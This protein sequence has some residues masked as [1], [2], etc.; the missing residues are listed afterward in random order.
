MCDIDSNQTHTSFSTKI[1]TNVRGHKISTEFVNGHS[2]LNHLKWKIFY[3]FTEKYVLK[4][5]YFLKTIT[6]S[7]K[8]THFLY[9]NCCT[10]TIT[11]KWQPFEEL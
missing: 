11:R 5:Y 7:G 4:A 9:S 10:Q 8:T 2:C 3:I 6:K 1:C